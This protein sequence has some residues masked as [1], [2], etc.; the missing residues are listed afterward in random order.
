M[1][2]ILPSTS[3]STLSK[4]IDIVS[5]L[6]K[7]FFIYTL[8]HRRAYN[9][10]QCN[11]AANSITVYVNISLILHKYSIFSNFS[12]NSISVYFPPKLIRAKI[13]QKHFICER[14]YRSANCRYNET[15]VWT[16][17]MQ[18]RSEEWEK[19]SRQ[20]NQQIREELDDSTDHGS[21]SSL[22]LKCSEILF[23]LF[24]LLIV[25]IQKRQC[26][27]HRQVSPFSTFFT[28]I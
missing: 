21:F 19:H 18:N 8:R 13:F 24:R 28:L 7:S 3:E 10:W 4:W 17:W 5:P 27:T 1:T 14:R 11:P 25:I 22:S 20:R 26:H 15:D 12:W 16:I 2:W 6:R 23:N 9:R